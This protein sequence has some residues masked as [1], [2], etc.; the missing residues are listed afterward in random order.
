MNFTDTH[1]PQLPI[2][3]TAFAAGYAH[4]MARYHGNDELAAASYVRGPVAMARLIFEHGGDCRQTA[5]AACLAGPAVFTI[6]PQEGLHARLIDFSREIC[7]FGVVS[8]DDFYGMIPTLSG[9]A[10]LFFQASAIM[11]LEQVRDTADDDLEQVYTDALK[12]Y[13]AAR[14]DVDAYK[15]DTRFEIAAMKITSGLQ[16]GSHLW[17]QQGRRSVAAMPSR[18]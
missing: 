11:L 18:I 8:Q 2:F 10:R 17:A 7:G 6:S 3:E 13:S 4:Y 9:D 5:A 12:L 1:L 16:N 15:L 14:G